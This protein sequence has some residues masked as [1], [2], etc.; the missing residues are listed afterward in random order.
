MLHILTLLFFLPAGF[1]HFRA[2]DKLVAVEYRKHREEWEKDRSPYG[3]FWSPP[4]RGWFSG[5][6]YS[7]RDRVAVSWLFVTPGWMENDP[8]ALDLVSRLRNSWM[9]AFLVAL[10]VFIL[11]NMM[12]MAFD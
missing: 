6:N 12:L 9:L 10:P 5:S 1:F 11:A 3:F 8:E 7:A 4:E 2:F